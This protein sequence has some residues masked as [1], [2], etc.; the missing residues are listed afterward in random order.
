MPDKFH[1]Q[2]RSALAD[3]QLQI[4]LDLNA[5]NRRQAWINAYASLPESW[6]RLRQRG[7]QIRAEIITNLDQILTQF[8]ENAQDNG[9]VIHQAADGNQ[10]TAIV[11]DIAQQHGAKLIA[12]SKSMLS[13]EIGLNRA[14]EVDGLRVVETDLGE[15]IVQLRN[16]PPAHIITPAVHL[17]RSDVGQTFHERLNVPYSEDIPTITNYARSALREVFLQ[18]DIGISG[19]NFGIADQGMLCIVTNEGNGR[20]VTSLPPVH[21]SLMGIERIVRN[22]DEL[23]LMLSLLPRAST[24]QKI[25]VYTN[26]IRAPRQ[27]DDGDGPNERHIIL[28]D[29]GRRALR[30]SLL[31]EALYCIR[32]GACLN[33]CPIFQEIGGHSYISKNGSI[34]NYSGPIGS[35]ISPGLFGYEEFGQLARASSLCGAC[36]DACPVDIDLPKL[37]LRIRAGELNATH[38]PP[39]KP[40]APRLLATG[41]RLYTWAATS[42]TRYQFAQR[43]AGFFS[44][45][46]S[47]RSHWMKFPAATGWGYSKDFPRPVTRTFQ[48]LWPQRI[49]QRPVGQHSETPDSQ[50]MVDPD[51]STEQVKKDQGDL[52]AEFKRELEALGG[53]FISCSRSDLSQKVLNCLH[54]AGITTI[55]SWG[56]D[57]FLEILLPE[58]EKAG[59]KITHE[60]DPEIKAG[61]TAAR[62]AVAGTGSLILPTG[63]G[64]PLTASL[65]PDIHLAILKEEDILTD[66]AQA[67]SLE[68]IRRASSTVLISGPSRTAD[69]E[70][71]LTVGV[72][73]PGQLYVFCLEQ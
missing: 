69:I 39:N 51:C 66:L 23:A 31:S 29:N 24:G 41:L 68:E 21:I 37:L 16:E 35:V 6:H 26:L 14:L 61:L 53:E 7:H 43:L 48:Q 73:G 72:H 28:I 65:L 44:R 32:C 56:T 9:L 45:I 67:F 13:E 22:L 63:Q 11:R 42:P 2:I 33:A 18:A 12:K 10:A 54:Q 1:T 52:R 17:R 25:T 60:P 30:E 20:M 59:I 64:R 36:K 19:V 71:T 58:L 55:Q 15:Y 46:I 8:V 3:E 34:S 5:R 70:M 49:T 47:P 4:A 57:Q 40:N 38:V 62:A 27:P 50:V